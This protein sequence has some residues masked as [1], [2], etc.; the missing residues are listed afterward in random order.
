MSNLIH[1]NEKGM[2]LPLGLMFLAIIAILGTTAVIVTTTDLK[3]G[4]NYRASEQAFYVAEAGISEAM[5]RL[6]LNSSDTNFIGEVPGITPTAGWGRYIVLQTGANKFKDDPDWDLS[7]DGLDDD[8]DNNEDDNIDETGETYPEVATLQSIDGTELNYLVKLYY[9]IE[10]SQFQ[11]GDGDTNEVVLYGQDFGY[12]SDAPTT[13]TH[14]VKVIESIGFA[15]NNSK[16]T[17]R[18][19]VSKLSLDIDAK[20]AIAC[21]SAP[22][23]GGATFISGFN[24]DV[25]T[26]DSVADRAQSTTDIT[27]ADLPFDG[28]NVDNHGGSEKYTGFNG[29]DTNTTLASDEDTINASGTE[30]EFEIR[31][32]SKIK[33][34]VSEGLPGVWTTNDPVNVITD[35]YGGTNITGPPPEAWKDESAGNVWLTL[36][37]LLGFTADELQNVLDKADV[38]ISDTTIIGGHMTLNK[39]PQGIIYIDNA[40]GNELKITANTPSYDDGWG[41]LYVKGDLDA[42]RLTFKGLIYVEGTVKLSGNFWVLG[43]MAVKGGNP[44]GTGGGT[45]LYSKDALNQ[46]VG[47][48]MD[49]IIISWKEVY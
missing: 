42:Q 22:S 40:G 44:T 38:T 14:P 36:A 3:I 27:G 19:E 7:D 41:L 48:A 4:S 6:N 43:A 9:K 2:V 1:K 10:D 35:V 16:R 11:N 39:V 28:N 18:V 8:L 20:A 46:K 33:N 34:D 25:S 15:Q 23:F 26:S 5:H 47:D 32:G 29:T 12:G 49:H 13:G 30:D 45:F 31:Y 24:H 17:I 37:Q 21:D